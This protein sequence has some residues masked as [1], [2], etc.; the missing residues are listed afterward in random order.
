L[1]SVIIPVYNRT[2][3]LPRAVNSVLNQTYDNLEIIVVDDGSTEDIEGVLDKFD[4]VRIHYIRHEANRGVAAARNTGMR[5]AHGE[6]VAFLDSDDEW[7]ERKI[8]RQLSDLIERGDDYQISYHAVDSYSD[9]KS[10]HVTH[11]TDSRK[12]ATYCKT[13]LGHVG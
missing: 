11:V 12:R 3:L 2:D 6:Y 8:E 9:A 5:F 10:R 4:D 7:F 13:L 1:I